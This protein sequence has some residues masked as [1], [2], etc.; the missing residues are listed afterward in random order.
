MNKKFLA[1]INTIVIITALFLFSCKKEYSTEELKNM[2]ISRVAEKT[3]EDSTNISIKEWIEVGEID[4]YMSYVASFYKNNA[5]DSL[6]Y[7][8][9][10]EVNKSGKFNMQSFNNII[11]NRR[12]NSVDEKRRYEI[13]SDRNY[14]NGF[15]LSNGESRFYFVVRPQDDAREVMFVMSFKRELEYGKN[16]LVNEYKNEKYENVRFDLFDD[17]RLPSFEY[18]SN[19]MYGLRAVSSNSKEFFLFSPDYTEEDFTIMLEHYGEGG[20]I[21]QMT[22]TDMELLDSSY[23]DIKLRFRAEDKFKKQKIVY[24]TTESSLRGEFDTKSEY[25]ITID[26]DTDDGERKTYKL[27]N[28]ID[29]R[30]DKVAADDMRIGMI[31]NYYLPEDAIIIDT[32]TT[33]FNDDDYT[34]YLLSATYTGQKGKQ[35]GIFVFTGESNN[36]VKY[37]GV[38]YLGQ[39]LV[40]FGNEEEQQEYITVD[41][42]RLLDHNKAYIFT[43]N[44]HNEESSSESFFIE[45]NSNNRMYMLESWKVDVDNSAIEIKGKN[46]SQPYIFADYTNR[47][48]EL[49]ADSVYTKKV[50]IDNSGKWFLQIMSSDQYSD[51]EKEIISKALYS[52]I[53]SLYFEKEYFSVIDSFCKQDRIDDAYKLFKY[54]EMDSEYSEQSLWDYALSYYWAAYFA[55]RDENYSYALEC[56]DEYIRRCKKDDIVMKGDTSE[57]KRLIGNNI[58]E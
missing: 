29:S 52:N 30:W 3:G 47:K 4:G 25:P 50:S 54:F 21:E 58:Q 46:Y 53:I 39:M 19:A 27:S 41:W 9:L 24:I 43:V 16:I 22:M 45:F 55:Y 51:D 42:D 7:L 57:L 38:E 15:C 20:K 1:I 34:D 33:N 14:T 13:I 6:S 17:Y 12:D 36:L 28:T 23:K 5:N 31:L 49:K 26:I 40:V 11:L 18:H 48:S 32:Y 2:A 10:F 37:L 56:I 8:G 44:R 35:A